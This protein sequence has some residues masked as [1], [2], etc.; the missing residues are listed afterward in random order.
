MGVAVGADV[1]PGH[2]LRAQMRRHRILILL[3]PAGLTIASRKLRL[4]R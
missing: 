4:P 3:A 1:E 2:L